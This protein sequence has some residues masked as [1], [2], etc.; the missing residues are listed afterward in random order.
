MKILQ[1]SSVPVSFQG[2]TEKVVWEISKKLSEKHEITILQTNLY[3]PEEKSSSA[4]K[5]N[6]KIITCKND[7]FLGG[8][9]FSKEFKR[10]LKEIYKN[11]DIIHI[12][13]YGRFTSDFSLK[14]LKNKKPIVFTAHGFFHS[15]KANLIKK[16]HYVLKG[17]L[18]KNANVCTALTE[19]EKKQYRRLGVKE[20]KIKVIPN[21]IDID[22]FNVKILREFG[23]KYSDGKKVL[24][25]VGRIHES[26]GIQ[27][28]IEAI[29]DLDLKFLIVG[30]DAGYKDILER[31]INNLGIENKVKI[32]E[33][34]NDVE[35]AKIYKISD[36]FVLFSEWEG[37][38]ITSIEAMAAGKP[39][40]VSNRGALPYLV[41]NNQTG[42]VVEFPKAEKLRDKIIFL[43]EN[44]KKAKEMGENGKG[45]AKKYDWKNI[46]KQYEEVYREAI[47]GK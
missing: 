7:R 21:G 32:L 6:V 26:K 29:K 5:D 46:I 38:G 41:K 3:L 27:Y 16:L 14:F 31:K 13:G 34:I 36:M 23:K 10:K 28:V 39:V 47:N 37:F 35:L 17:R 42:F 22:R 19:L 43:L 8:Y 1:I 2:G 40:I 24:L 33:N 9:G 4:D 45:E 12:H 11:F 18:L 20:E 15:K 25:Y 30:N 44:G